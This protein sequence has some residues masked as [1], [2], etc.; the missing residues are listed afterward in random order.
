MFTD[1]IPTSLDVSALTEKF[2]PARVGE[3][4]HVL[5]KYLTVMDSRAN[6]AT[7][8]ALGFNGMRLHQPI[9]DVHQSA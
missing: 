9:D 4:D 1:V 3:L 2:E 5:I 8:L 6:G 7:T